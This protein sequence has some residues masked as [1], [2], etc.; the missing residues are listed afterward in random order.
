MP[1]N[2][3]T[4]R[5]HVRQ[6]AEAESNPATQEWRVTVVE[7]HIVGSAEPGARLAPG[8]TAGRGGG[9]VRPSASRLPS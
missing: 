9:A 1:A 2:R 4:V 3:P 5:G 7:Q 8:S 6:R